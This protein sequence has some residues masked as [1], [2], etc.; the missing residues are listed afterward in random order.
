MYN[1]VWR[2]V[3]GQPRF[4]KSNVTDVEI[5]CELRVPSIDCFVRKARLKYLARMCKLDLP[6]LMALLQTK[7]SDGRRMPWSNLILTDLGVLKAA[8]PRIFCELPAP[9]VDAEPFWEL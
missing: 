8:L 4:G 5:R 6:P 3:Y 1:R 9:H 2:R 7:L